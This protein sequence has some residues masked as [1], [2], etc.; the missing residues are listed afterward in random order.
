M[1]KFFWVIASLIVPIPL[2]GCSTPGGITHEK[3]SNSDLYTYALDKT[4]EIALAMELNPQKISPLCRAQVRNEVYLLPPDRNGGN[5]KALGIYHLEQESLLL[6]LFRTA[7]Y[8]RIRA[9]CKKNVTARDCHVYA[10][11]VCIRERETCY[12]IPCAI[13]SR[14]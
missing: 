4:S 13:E 2:F 10:I 11:E 3:P 9:D 6:C 5:P 12:Q 1:R 8:D 7:C 14:L